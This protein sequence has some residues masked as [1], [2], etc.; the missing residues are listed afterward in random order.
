VLNKE[1]QSNLNDYISKQ[2][3]SIMNL[4]RSSASFAEALAQNR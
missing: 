2:K 4:S 1:V 3:E